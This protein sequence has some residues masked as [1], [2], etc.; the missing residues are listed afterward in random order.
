MPLQRAATKRRPCGGLTR[1][2]WQRGTRSSAPPLRGGTRA[3]HRS[4]APPPRPPG[5]PSGRCGGAPQRLLCSAARRSRPRPR[6]T[7]A[8]LPPAPS[9][10]SARFRTLRPALPPPSPA[11]W[12]HFG[13]RKAQRVPSSVTPSAGSRLLPRNTRLAPLAQ[14]GGAR[15]KPRGTTAPPQ[16]PPV[17]CGCG[18]APCAPGGRGRPSCNPPAVRRGGTFAPSPSPGRDGNLCESAARSSRPSPACHSPALHKRSPRPPAHIPLLR[19][20]AGAELRLGGASSSHRPFSLSF[21]PSFLPPSRPPSAPRPA[22]RQRHHLRPPGAARLTAPQPARPPLRGTAEPRRAEPAAALPPIPCAALRRP[23]RQTDVRAHPG[24]AAAV[25]RWPPTCCSTGGGGEA[26]WAA[27]G[28]G[29][30][31]DPLVAVRRAA[32]AR[33]A[34]RP[35]AGSGRALRGV[36]AVRSAVRSAPAGLCAATPDGAGAVLPVPGTSGAPDLLR[37][38]RS[39]GSAGTGRPV[40]GHPRWLSVS[41]VRGCPRRV[42]APVRKAATE[43]RWA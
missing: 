36:G 43:L 34:G 31:P 27:R 11:P 4:S 24:A 23:R 15:L 38:G 37:S 25:S 3:R 9:G 29:P 21:R 32:G 14:R 5:R 35:A 2:R 41:P 7:G 18:T 22:S 20:A 16:P 30:D 10:P 40:G 13:V 19:A 42:P 39:T 28:E 6:G 1:A 8:A 26:G 17:R 33:P 12:S